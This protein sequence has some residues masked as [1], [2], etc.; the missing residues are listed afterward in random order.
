MKLLSFLKMKYEQHMMRRFNRLLNKMRENEN[1][2]WYPEFAIGADEKIHKLEIKLDQAEYH[3]LDRDQ[4]IIM[5]EDEI[6]KEKK[7]GNLPEWYDTI[8]R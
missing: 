7:Y 3:L 5:L 4:R 8:Y 2:A 1:L 6:E